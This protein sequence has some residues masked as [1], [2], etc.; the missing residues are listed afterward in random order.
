[1]GRQKLGKIKIY[2]FSLVPFTIEGIIKAL[3]QTG[4]EI[5]GFSGNQ[6]EAL[7]DIKVNHSDVL[8][9]D[10]LYLDQSELKSFLSY[11]FNSSVKEKII[12][13]TGNHNAKFLMDVQEM[14]IH[15]LLSKK[16]PKEK[17]YEAIEIVHK[18]G[19]YFDNS[20]SY[21]AI[22][23]EHDNNMIFEKYI[24]FLSKREKDIL[25]L[26]SNG[27]KNKEIAEKLFI[28][29]RTVDTHKTHILTKLNLK[30]TA[31]L[32]IFAG[33]NNIKINS[34]PKLEQ[35]KYGKFL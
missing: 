2:I 17:L 18:R 3:E 1:L 25:I 26:I 16:A 27:L 35:T 34:L 24:S 29:T 10:D 30:S 7:S 6:N 23:A 14:G 31:Y 21:K 15:G 8:L 32:T 19:F 33:K 28:S 11:L 22:I 9:I 20:F 13:Y 4:A 5:S 12:L